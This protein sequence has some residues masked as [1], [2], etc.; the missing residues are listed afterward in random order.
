MKKL[1]FT[2]LLPVCNS[3][4]SQI[5]I[6]EIATNNP[7]VLADEDLDYPNWIE[8]YNAS[9]FEVDLAGYSL[10]D[11]GDWNEWVFPETLLA[12]NA[13]LIVFTSAKNRNC[14][15]CNGPIDHWETAVFDNDTWEYFPGTSAPDADWNDVTFAGLWLTGLGGFGY[16]DADDNTTIASGTISVYY[17]KTF[18]VADK[19][20]LIS[21]ILSMDYDDGFIAYLNGI[22]IGRAYLTGTPTY[23]TYA[24]TSHEA[25]MYTGG[26]P[27]AFTID[28]AL[29]SSLLV[30]GE[31]VLAVEVHNQTAGSSDITGRTFLHFGIATAEE[32]YEDTPPWFLTGSGSDNL[33]TSF[34]LNAG[35]TIRLYNPVATLIDSTT[36]PVLL[37]GHVK[38]R[39]SDGGDWCYSDNATPDEIN[40]GTCFNGYAS[41]PVFITPAGSYVGDVDVEIAGINIY[42][43][44][45]G[46]EPTELSDDYLSP[47]HLTNTGPVRARSYAIGK[48]PSIIAT[49]TYLI[50]ED[51]PLPIVSISGSPCDLFDL[52][53]GCIGAYDNAEG[54][55]PN[56]PRVPVAIE[57]FSADKT[58]Q[59]QTNV[60]FEVAGNSSIYYFPQHSMEFTCDE[61]YN[62]T[63]DILYNPFSI[64]KPS[65]TTI[66][67]FRVRNMDQ[68]FYGARMKDV[69]ANR[70]ALPTHAI[71]AGYQNVVAYINGDYW[72]EYSAREE[73][74]AYFL[75]DN[76]GCDPNRVDL[77]KTGYGGTDWYEVESGSDTAFWALND[78]LTLNDMT[79]PVY[80]EAAMQ[81]IDMENWVDYF[82]LQIFIQNEEWLHSLENNL[83]MF[84]AYEPEIKWHFVLWDLAFG[85]YCSNCNT[86][87]GSLENPFNSVYADMF[88]AVLANEEFKNYFVDRFADLLNYYFTP[89]ITNAIIT[90]NAD[91]LEPEIYDQDQKWDSGS[92]AEWTNNVNSLKT[93]YSSRILNQRNN[94]ED[95]FNLNDQVEI[96][97]DV[98]PPGA[99]Y[100]QISTIIPQDLPW[101]GV[102]FDGVPVTLTAIAN[103][104]YIFT[105]WDENTFIVDETSVT[106]TNNISEDASFTANFSGSLVPNPVIITEINYNSEVTLNS[107]DWIELYNPSAFEIDLTGYTVGSKYYYNKYKLP[108][109]TVIPA[110]S[111]LVLAENLNLFASIHPSV[112]NVLGDLDFEL[113]NAGDSIT[114]TDFSGT[115][116]FAFSFADNKPW[117]VTADNYG[118]TLELINEDAD[119]SIPGSWFAGC[120]GGSPGVEFTPCE[121]NPI[122]DE[123]NYNSSLDEDAGDW[124]ELYNTGAELIDV[125][126]WVIKDKNNNS[127]VIPAG[128]M[129]DGNN[130]L[131]IYQDE[132]K[133]SSE[134]PVITNK[135][136]PTIFGF[137]REND[138]VRIYDAD[139]ILFQSVGFDNEAPYPVSP[140]GGG[141][142]LQIISFTENL[143]DP[144]NWMESCP[145]GSP[146]T[147]YLTPCLTG[148]E[149]PEILSLFSISPNPATD[150]IFLQSQQNLQNAFIQINDAAGKTCSQLVFNV[151]NPFI[152]IHELPAGIYFMK[153]ETSDSAMSAKFIKL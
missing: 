130:Y 146:G 84:K 106:F 99:G 41:T 32:L 150:V 81:K 58:R 52:G 19:T 123:I 35:E 151:S 127:F 70:L 143:N 128:T 136:G 53:V 1:L 111:Y 100:I 72:G 26:N 51:T 80:Y 97:I 45:D 61:E 120:I 2:L 83:R 131:V 110:N 5:V 56:N 82:A 46:D 13:H 31:N 43:T 25:M 90:E 129:I 4:S 42:Y 139:G 95:Y 9:A 24:T 135:I 59:F 21:A 75:S 55:E 7:V 33:H 71:A 88:N 67:G 138:V 49:S 74:D 91:E 148:V 15:T 54:W 73:L 18:N 20:K 96:T 112:S 29:L 105:D 60:R 47:V 98:N 145:E 78:F 23:D 44:T 116:L 6:N 27:Q 142:A 113:D 77:I 92:P 132:D 38:A 101:E 89:A 122:V 11:G 8:L 93:F 133:F 69:V 109:H 22:E 39:I 65:L 68:D 10:S 114:M 103:P 86:L 64:D 50:D 147:E 108:N 57:Y 107:G 87:E 34:N 144:A 104:G 85:Q 37:T 28:S 16:G 30:N 118:R 121:E 137:D 115:Q 149:D 141:T 17:R 14:L 36:V 140:D 48:L 152:N 117:P 79:D 102:Y 66:H 126:G 40:S 94:I 62:N 63:G 134:F 153:I 12:S 125:S 119:P 124:I 3:V 76:F